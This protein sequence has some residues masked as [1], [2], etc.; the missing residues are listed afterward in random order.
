MSNQS[1][2]LVAE[3]GR[4]IVVSEGVPVEVTPSDI[5]VDEPVAAPSDPESEAEPGVEDTVPVEPET[6]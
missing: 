6:A 5:V 1:A 2:T 3:D 4:T